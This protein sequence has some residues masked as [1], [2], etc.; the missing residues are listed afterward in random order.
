MPAEHG[1]VV[2]GK[3]RLAFAGLAQGGRADVVVKDLRDRW[4]TMDSVRLNNTLQEAWR[5]RPDAGSQWSHCA[6][7]PLYMA[8]EGLAGLRPL[9][10]GFKRAEIRPQ[11]ADLEQFELTAH[12]PLGPLEFSARGRLGARELTIQLPPA[13]EGELVLNRQEQVRLEPA[14]GAAPAGHVRYRLPAGSTTKIGLAF[15]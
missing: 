5:T 4:A 13:C 2:S 9:A 10:P 1:I 8:F 14:Q 11:L 12:T 6:V 7:A 15:T 3:C